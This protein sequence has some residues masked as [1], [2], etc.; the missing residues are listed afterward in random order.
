VEDDLGTNQVMLIMT[1]C[2]MD[3]TH[4]GLTKLSKISKAAIA[5]APA[6]CQNGD[7]VVG[8]QLAL[9]EEFGIDVFGRQAD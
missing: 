2:W 3:A 6:R 8:D 9:P 7:L 1:K 4:G 5:H